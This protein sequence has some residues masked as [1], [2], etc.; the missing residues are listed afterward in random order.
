[1]SPN[2][3]REYTIWFTPGGS[4]VYKM[5]GK[6]P[7]QI[8]SIWGGTSGLRVYGVE[9]LIPEFIAELQKTIGEGKK[10]VVEI[11]CVAPESET[12]PWKGVSVKI[13]DEDRQIRSLKNFCEFLTEVFAQAIKEERLEVLKFD[14]PM[15]PMNSP[16]FWEATPFGKWRGYFFDGRVHVEGSYLPV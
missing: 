15:H 9:Q 13:Q 3:Q 4:F 2:S 8:I 14:W 11:P 12:Y 10:C 1:M 16:C 7:P 5:Y 6:E